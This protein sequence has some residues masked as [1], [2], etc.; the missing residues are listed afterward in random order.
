MKRI[1]LLWSL[2][3]G[4]MDAAT[5]LLLILT[6][7]L[8]MKLLA[9]PPLPAGTEIL[10]SW[11]GTFV[12]ATGLCY[13]LC[14]RGRTPAETVWTTTAIVRSAVAV[15]LAASIARGALP[16]AWWPVAAA[17]AAVALV[18]AIGLKAGWWRD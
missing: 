17:D 7:S 11:I 4:A 3:V 10:M 18:Q 12:L 1:A 6:P 9:I 13:G 5:G 15:F 16:A 14:L 8:V 2:A